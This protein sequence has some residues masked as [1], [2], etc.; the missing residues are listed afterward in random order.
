M[1]LLIVLSYLSLYITTH[2]Y[3]PLATSRCTVRV[4][5]VAATIATTSTSLLLLAMHGTRI[6]GV[7]RGVARIWSVDPTIF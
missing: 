1:F 4:V 5:G 6:I 2:H 3:L 7:R